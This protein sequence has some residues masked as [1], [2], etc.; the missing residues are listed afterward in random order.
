MGAGE[1]DGRLTRLMMV[2]NDFAGGFVL[3]Y[4]FGED[5]GDVNDADEDAADNIVILQNVVWFGGLLVGINVRCTQ[6]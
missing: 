4:D 3:G 5:L 2:C 1:A 6:T